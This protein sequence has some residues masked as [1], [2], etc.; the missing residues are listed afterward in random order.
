[1][2]SVG[3]VASLLA[4]SAPGYYIRTMGGYFDSDMLNITLPALTV[5]SLIKLVKSRSNKDIFL[6]AVFT[7]LY[8]WWYVSSYSLNLSLLITFVLYT[9]VADRR[10]DV[11]Y[12]AAIL[13]AV[14]LIRFDYRI[15]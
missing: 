3:V 7:A 12:K 4:V 13:M 9:L 11:N 8:S 1:M 14:A 2:L 5:W 6:P 10:N 15:L